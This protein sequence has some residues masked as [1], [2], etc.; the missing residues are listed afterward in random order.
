[1][2]NKIFLLL[3]SLVVILSACER[4]IDEFKANSNGVDFSKYVAIGNSMTAGYAD[5][6]LYTS[7]QENSVG[8]IISEQ[9]AYVGGGAFAQPMIA[10]EEGVGFLQVPTGLYFFTKTTLQIVPVYNCGGD[11][12]LGQT[13]KPYYANPTA[14]QEQLG[15]ELFT[16]PSVP[17]PYQ[18]MGVPGATVQALV[19]PGYGNYNPFFKR[20]QSGPTASILGDALAQ[21]PTFFSLWIG[22]NDVLA[23][24]LQ[25]TDVL[26]TPV[27]SFAK[28]MNMV[29]G[30]LV[31]SSKSPKGVIGNI[32]DI[33]N[34]PFF[35]T[36]SQ[37]LPYDNV[38][39]DTAQAAGLNILYGM[40]GYPNWGWKP[41][42]NPFVIKTTNGELK[43]MEEGDQFLL[44]LPTD[45]LKCEG[46]GVAN[47]ATYQL[48]PIPAE[49][50]LEKSEIAGLQSKVDSYNSIIKSVASNYG[51]ALADMNTYLK[52]FESGLIFDGVTYTTT[53]VS[54][55]AFSTDGIHLNPRGNA[56]VANYFIS[57][58]ESK[59]GCTIPK[60]DQTARKGLIFP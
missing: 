60:A 58:I 42:R 43:K 9:L 55:G 38:V 51:L 53:F 45:K 17:G 1:M 23:S 28:Y 35:N 46:M 39:L 30:A 40:Y 5:G 56:I 3:I 18:N 13:M 26:A 48:N 44:T 6:A 49:Y 36:I 7:G 14:T 52:S 22:N 29:V 47:P 12:V 54:G 57:A 59:Y 24:A 34:I 31:N 32:P 41:G 50:V 37:K 10:T 15:G 25:G 20:F 33:T 8:K 16:P 2:K 4:E 19:I 11:T 21:E 27:D